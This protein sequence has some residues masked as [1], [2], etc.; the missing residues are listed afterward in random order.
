MTEMQTTLI[1]TLSKEQK[2]NT[3][4]LAILAK[5]VAEMKSAIIT[6]R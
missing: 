1:E 6:D 4:N 2:L 3:R 5:K